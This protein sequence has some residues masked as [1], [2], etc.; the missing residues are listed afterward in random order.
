MHS[1]RGALVSKKI[2]Q[3]ANEYISSDTLTAVS[4]GSSTATGNLQSVGSSSTAVGGGKA[5]PAPKKKK[6]QAGG[7]TAGSEEDALPV[8]G[9]LHWAAATH[10]PQLVSQLLLAGANPC[11]PEPALGLGPVHL[12]ALGRMRSTQQLR[13]LCQHQSGYGNDALARLQV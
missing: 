10:R 2:I 5:T 7:S 11:E 8:W 4:S 9:A 12:A 13:E 6:E 1:C 3:K